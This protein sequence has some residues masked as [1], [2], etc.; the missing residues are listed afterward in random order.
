[1]TALPLTFLW[2]MQTS[3]ATLHPDLVAYEIEHLMVD[4]TG[5]NPSFFSTA[6]TPCSLYF[7]GAPNLGR[8]TAAQWLRVAFH[9]FVTADIASGTGGLD[10]SIGYETL[11]AENVGAAFND[12]LSFFAFFQSEQISMSDLIALGVAAVTGTC[13]GQKIPFRGGR[14]DAP[15]AGPS[16]VPEPETDVPNTLSRFGSAGFDQSDAIA[17]TACGHTLGGV[18]NLNFPQVVPP[19]AVSANNEDGR[20]VFDTS[21]AAFDNNV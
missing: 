10:A 15:Q 4:S 21:P 16:G 20:I 18:R 12:S 9:D 3:Y 5:C 13:G 19:S 17:L 1:M 14:I 6:I 11:R 2:L 8:E 7:S